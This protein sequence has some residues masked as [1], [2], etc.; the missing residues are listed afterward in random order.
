M[1]V[2]VRLGRPLLPLVDVVGCWPV[3]WMEIVLLVKFRFVVLMV[4]CEVCQ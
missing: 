4:V 2:L 1:E 3:E